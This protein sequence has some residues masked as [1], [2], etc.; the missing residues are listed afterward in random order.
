MP[1]THLAMR[2]L[3][4]LVII[5]PVVYL[6]AW[7][8]AYAGMLG[9]DFSYYFAYLGWAWTFRGGELPTYIWYFSFILFLPLVV[10]SFFLL[11]RNG[12]RQQP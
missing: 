6:V 7:T 12:Q 5:V 2:T 4:K 8:V 3:L 10:L 9:L 1:E 11:R